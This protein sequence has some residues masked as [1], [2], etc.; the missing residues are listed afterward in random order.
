M[1]SNYEMVVRLLLAAFIGGIIGLE[2]EHSRRPAGLRTHML[3]TLG[4]TLI[5]LISLDVFD[6]SDSARLAAQVVSG[7]GFL[8]AGTIIRTGGN[9][10]GLTT[11]AGLWVCAGVGLAIGAGY[12]FGAIVTM[13]IVVLILMSTGVLDKTLLKQHHRT[14]EISVSHDASVIGEVE[15]LFNK[16]GV[17]IKRLSIINEFDNVG[18]T[19][20]R[21]IRIMSEAENEV[22]FNKLSKDICRI[23]GVI[24][25]STSKNQI[26]ADEIID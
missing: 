10:I 14:V 3:V 9:I 18:H 11:A 13:I 2:R 4:S 24:K 5:M 19:K 26:S 23:E 8:G 15:E 21:K 7:I 20:I 16:Y 17:S 12:Y 25:L 6:G 22:D 1:I